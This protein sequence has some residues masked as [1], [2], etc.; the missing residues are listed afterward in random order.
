MEFSLWKKFC[1]KV[2][3]Q[4]V[5]WMS[6]MLN[7]IEAKRIIFFYMIS[8]NIILFVHYENFI[9]YTMRTFIIIII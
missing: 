2:D 6:F 9:L 4:A 7:D 3:G 1:L 8:M 5:S